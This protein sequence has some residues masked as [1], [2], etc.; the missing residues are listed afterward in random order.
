MELTNTS[1]CLNRQDDNTTVCR[2]DTTM[3]ALPQK[4]ENATLG[5]LEVKPLDVQSD[6]EFAFMD[7]VRLGTF[8]RS[9]MLRKSNRKI[10]VIQCIGY[11]MVSFF[12]FF[13]LVSKHFDGIT[14]MAEILTINITKG[15][16]RNWWSFAKY[17]RSEKTILTV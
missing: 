4:A 13:Y 7:L 16:Y 12:F 14:Q 11:T 9:L 15:N 6:Q 10:L 3:V 8:A 17:R 1:Y 5:Y 2:P